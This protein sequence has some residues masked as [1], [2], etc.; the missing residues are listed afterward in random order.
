[1]RKEDKVITGSMVLL[2]I[3]LNVGAI[4]LSG[5]D[6]PSIIEVPCYD[7]YKNLIVNTTCEHEGYNL[8]TLNGQFADLGNQ[9][10]YP[11]FLMD[12]LLIVFGSI[13][14]IISRIDRY[15]L[16]GRR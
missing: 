2:F 11:I 15:L 7:R 10:K 5:L 9:M 8:N 3:L 13:F 1:M 16:G 12:G 14:F 4:Y 6:E